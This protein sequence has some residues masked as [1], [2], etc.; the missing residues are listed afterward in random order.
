MAK[1][2]VIFSLVVLFI[3]PS[4]YC[5]DSIDILT[6]YLEADLEKK[7]HYQA[8]PLLV[9]FNYSAE[10]F[11]NKIGLKVPGQVNFI[12][13]PFFNTVIGPDKNIE[14]GSNF[15]L[16]YSLTFL[17][18]IHPYIKGGIGALYMSQHTEEQSTQYNFLPQVGGGIQ[19]FLTDNLAFNLEYRYRHLSNASIKNPNSGID[20][21]LILCGFSFFFK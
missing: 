15:L 14:V 4:S 7:D 11:L 12:L 6:G 5:L 19:Y 20:S 8:V 2:L 17:D 16:K 21:D 9:G 10:P 18:K 1:I 13:E 3:V